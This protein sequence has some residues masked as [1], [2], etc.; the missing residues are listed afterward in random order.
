M[1]TIALAA[2]GVELH[3]YSSQGY[4]VAYSLAFA[5]LA[6]HGDCGARHEI[7][8]KE[9]RTQSSLLT[10]LVTLTKFCG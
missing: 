10:L 6:A 9:A 3:Y 1:R 7:Q 4:S 5:G 8:D 2:V